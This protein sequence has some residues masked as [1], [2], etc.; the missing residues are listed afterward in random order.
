MSQT[1]AV[2]PGEF[3]GHTN[4]LQLQI[5][6]SLAHRFVVHTLSVL[7]GCVAMCKIMIRVK[8]IFCNVFNEFKFNPN[9]FI[10]C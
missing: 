10:Q 5:K 3:K 8:K 7:L 4:K 9:V 6:P 1:D 2:V